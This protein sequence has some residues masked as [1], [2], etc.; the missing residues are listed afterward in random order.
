MS[1][2]VELHVLKLLRDMDMSARRI[3]ARLDGVTRENFI[4][5]DNLDLQDIVARR[6]SII[7][8]AAAALHKK[9]AGFCEAHPEIPLRQ[10]RGMRNILIHD[11]DGIDWSTV[12]NTAKLALPD[13]VKAIEPFT[14]KE[15]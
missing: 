8:E 12:W 5:T 10:A 9:H 1:D 6:L 15:N 13:L 14:K 11:Y 4:D 2:E 7:G 3:V